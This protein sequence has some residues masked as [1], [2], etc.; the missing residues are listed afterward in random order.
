MGFIETSY[1]GKPNLSDVNID[2]ALNMGSYGISSTGDI[3]I[4][5]IVSSSGEL[6]LNDSVDLIGVN[7]FICNDYLGA[8]KSEAS[9]NIEWILTL[10][11]GY[12]Y[13]KKFRVPSNFVESTINLIGY[14]TNT[15]SS[16]YK[17]YL[18]KYDP[19]SGTYTAIQE[20]IIPA[21][22]STPTELTFQNITINAG[23][24]Y[25]INT[26]SSQYT[27][28]FGSKGLKICC[29]L[30]SVTGAVWEVI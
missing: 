8:I 12:V 29:N 4:D 6:T 11:D 18:S 20:I 25:C 9:N 7:R 13:S 27:K 30:S 17:A 22:T 10:N 19:D 5:S 2:S 1:G 23:E 28:F 15:Y 26:Q 24:L 16:T 21:N 3:D 14:F